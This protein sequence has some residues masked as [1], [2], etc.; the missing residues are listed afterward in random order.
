MIRKRTIATMAAL[1]GFTASVALL[2]GLPSAK[3]D[4]LSDLRVNQELLQRRVD[5][6]AQVPTSGNVFGAGP[7]GPGVGVAAAGGSFP[8]SFLIPGTDTSLRVG[9][10]VTTTAYYWFSGGPV[11]TNTN[12]TSPG[13][14]G[15]TASTPLDWHGQLV[16]GFA[17]GG[18]GGPGPLST[19]SLLSL[20]GSTSAGGG[21]PRSHLFSASVRQSGLNFETRTPT[22][23][24][25]ARTF[26]SFDFNG[27]G[28][29]GTG[30]IQQA[31]NGPGTSNSLTPRMLYAYGTI[32]GFLAGN[33]NSNFKDSD[34]E[35]ESLDFGGDVGAGGVVR[36]PQVRYTQPLAAWGLPGALSVS[37]EVPNTSMNL[38][39]GA[40]ASDTTVAAVLV[41]GAVAGNPAKTLMPD[42]TAAWFI[43][44]PW[45][46]FDVAGVIRDLDFQDGGKISR[47]Y[48]GWGAHVSG[49]VKPRWFGWNRDYIVW[50]FTGGQ[51]IGRYVN[52]GG[53]QDLVSNWSAPTLCAVQTGAGCA[54][55]AGTTAANVALN[56]IA[57]PIP[58]WGAQVGYQHHWT[59][60][61]RSNASI[62]INHKD[63]DSGL[64]AAAGTTA[65]PQLVAV[66]KETMTTHV[67][68]I[69]A[70]VS[71]ADFAVE[72]Q[73]GHRVTLANIRGDVNTLIG[74]FN[75]RF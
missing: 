39:A 13:N 65:R 57:K 53:N 59:D 54:G 4:E 38:P 64:L 56:I 18:L 63:V 20:T 35:P 12:Q 24:G 42:F 26:L 1:G 31:G 27:P 49:D 16:P 47:E 32:G 46:H 37:A 66:N 17:A 8:R 71:F 55:L 44:Q 61:L 15:Q 29:T 22:A 6:L 74:R 25:E 75:M 10:N 43:P 9:G 14:N 58:E 48:I 67:N 41:T 72:Y 62:G 51:G 2:S 45:G 36:L 40:V 3:A 21:R 73:W 33:A 11:N 30:I 19:A 52:A 60:N 28:G 7:A 70:P 69:W 23:W 68:L 50:S 5:Q 34:A